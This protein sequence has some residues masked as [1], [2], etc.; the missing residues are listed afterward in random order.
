MGRHS[1]IYLRSPCVQ[2]ICAAHEPAQHL[3][4]D[5]QVAVRKVCGKQ[6]FAAVVYAQHLDDILVKSCAELVVHK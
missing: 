3:I 6:I 4:T 5:S 2:I 1:G